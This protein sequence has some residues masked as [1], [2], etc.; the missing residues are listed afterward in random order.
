MKLASSQATPKPSKLASVITPPLGPRLPLPGQPF[1]SD[2]TVDTASRIAR[3]LAHDH[4]RR[5]AHQV[6]YA[7]SAEISLAYQVV[8]AGP[9]DLPFVRGFASNLIWNWE[10]PSYAPPH[11]VRL[12]RS[13][14][15]G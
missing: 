8:G 7:R 2:S 13:T 11:L 12:A 9:V 3:R 4:T 14:A 1:A 6:S 10:L 15:D 5:V